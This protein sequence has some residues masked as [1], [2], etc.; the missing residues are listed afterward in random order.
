MLLTVLQ[1][2]VACKVK[3]NVLYYLFFWVVPI[4]FLILVIVFS[5]CFP[6][7]LSF[8]CDFCAAFLEGKLAYLISIICFFT[9]KVLTFSEFVKL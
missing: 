7:C 3:I 9:V 8:F 6:S 5:V 1:F 2:L 4:S